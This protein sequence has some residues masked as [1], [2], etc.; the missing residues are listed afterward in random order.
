M[1]I[2]QVDL[3]DAQVPELFQPRMRDLVIALLQAAFLNIV[4]RTPSSTQQPSDILNR[5][6]L[7]Q[8]AGVCFEGSCVSLVRSRKRN[9]SP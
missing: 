5:R 3:V 2:T 8:L 6:K 7:D 1:F 9:P 4:D